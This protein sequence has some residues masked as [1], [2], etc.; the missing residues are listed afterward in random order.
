MI[1]NCNEQILNDVIRVGLVTASSCDME[2]PMQVPGI[3]TMAGTKTVGGQ[4]VDRIGALVASIATH[5][6]EADQA[7]MQTGLTLKQQDKRT[8]AGITV[9]Q[10]LEVPITAGLEQLRPQVQA[11]QLVDIHI[12]L[13]TANGNR[14]VLYAVPGSV[15]MVLSEQGVDQQGTLQ[16]DLT[17]MSHAILLT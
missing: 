8:A 2:V 12:I 14:Y 11:C 17:S 16:I 7:E 1:Q 10:Q 4:V 3:E 6:T 13:Y 9:Q 5:P 15:S